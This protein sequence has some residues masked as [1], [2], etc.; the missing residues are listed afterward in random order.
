MNVFKQSRVYF[1]TPIQEF[2]F[3]DKYSRFNPELGRRETWVETVRRTVDFLEEL[4][5]DKI[6]EEEYQDIYSSIL[7]MEVMPSMRLLSMA[8]PAARRNNISIYNCAYLPINSIESMV[9]ALLISMAGCGVGFSV[10][11]KYIDK[12]PL[13]IPR[14]NSHPSPIHIVE[15]SA[16]GWGVALRYGLTSWFDGFDIRFDYSQIRPEGA[17][18]KTKGGR[19]SGPEPLKAL[20]EFCR[21]TILGKNKLTPI[22]VHDIMCS[23]GQAAVS[24]GVR[25]T[26]M[27]SLFDQDDREMRNCKTGVFPSVR[28]NANNS[29]VWEDTDNQVK[30]CSSFLDMI[31]SGRGEPGIFSRRVA[32]RTKPDR[33]SEADFGSNPCG[34]I[35][36]RPFEFCNLSSAIA[37][38]GDTYED[39]RYK[40]EIAAKIGCIQS[41]ATHFPGLRDIWK[42]NCEEERLIG[43]D[44]TGQMDH[45]DLEGMFQRLKNDVTLTAI[46]M[47]IRLGINIPAATTCVKPSGNTS[48]LV[49]CS[50]GLHARWSPYYIRRV[51]VSAFS[52]IYRV[53]RSAGVP[54]SPEN[55]QKEPYAKTYVV[56]FPIASPDDAFTRRECSALDQCDMWLINKTYWTS[57][58]PSITVTYKDNEVIELMNWVWEYRDMIGGMS[59]LPES[60]AKYDQLPYEEITKE[61]YERLKKKFPEVDYSLLLLYENSD[62]T[63]SSTTPACEGDKCI[64]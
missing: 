46:E 37:R 44:I 42:E 23:I 34:E 13:I 26:A 32:N 35:N 47:A 9:E 15:D 7:N 20:L 40:V 3:Y 64:L 56:S 39:M 1:D 43:V 48:Q 41:L 52:P 55:G 57:H 17:V 61:E 18:L 51:R 59:F 29:A 14:N 63:T 24:G 45:G 2:Q 28:W 53:L 50:S 27:M 33:R 19:A 4:A 60:N 6:S 12:L 10:E 62:E 21:E 54:M 30:F 36:L 38:K 31:K 16:E 8:G 58:N 11:R 5:G 22:Q 25:R 49:N